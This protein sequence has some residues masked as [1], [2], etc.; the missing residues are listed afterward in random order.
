[1]FLNK[2]FDELDIPQDSTTPMKEALLA[3]VQQSGLLQRLPVLLEAA[4]DVMAARMQQPAEPPAT[5]PGDVAPDGNGSG[6]SNSNSNNSSSSA[7]GSSRGGGGSSAAVRT[8]DSSGNGDGSISYLSLSD[9]SLSTH[10]KHLLYIHYRLHMLLPPEEASLH[11][12]A[13]S[14][15]ALARAVH[16]A[17]QYDSVL[18]RQ[19]QLVTH[20]V[21]LVDIVGMATTGIPAQTAAIIPQQEGSANARIL[22]SSPQAATLFLSAHYVPSLVLATALTV[23]GL[24]RIEQ[25]QR[26]AAAAPSG[27]GSS[28]AAP[29]STSCEAGLDP[30]HEQDSCPS[31]TRAACAVSSWQQAREMQGDLTP[32]QQQ[33]FGLLGVD[34][35][36]V[37]WAAAAA[38][39]S[40]PTPAVLANNAS[41]LIMAYLGVIQ[42]WHTHAEQHQEHHQMRE[43]Q[44]RVH[45]LLPSL[46]LHY[47]AGLPNG[48]RFLPSCINT[49]Y[50]GKGALQ[51]WE[52]LQQ[53][54]EEDE[55]EE[56]QQFRPAAELAAELL[57]TVLTVSARVKKL[58]T[59]SVQG[60]PEAA[61]LAAVDPD[62]TPQ[63]CRTAYADVARLLV[64]LVELS[65]SLA[66][67]MADAAAAGMFQ[68]LSA[69]ECF[70]R[71]TATEF[72]VLEQPY[73]SIG[74][75]TRCAVR[76]IAGLFVPRRHQPLVRLAFSTAPG[77]RERQQLYSLL[78]SLHKLASNLWSR[79]PEAH[80]L[81]VACTDA[82]VA[83][84]PAPLMTQS[85]P[86]PAAP[87][88]ASTGGGNAASPH[89]TNTIIH[90]SVRPAGEWPA[91]ACELVSVLPS[92]VLAGRCCLVKAQ[93]LQQDTPPEV[94]GVDI[95]MAIALLNGFAPGL[96]SGMDGVLQPCQAWLGFPTVSQQLAAAGYDPQML[97]QAAAEAL[98]AW[99]DHEAAAGALALGNPSP[100]GSSFT[101][102]AQ[103][104]QAAGAALAVVAVPGVCN[105]PSCGNVDGPTELS[106]VSGQDKGNKCGRC[107]TA[108]YCSPQCQR[109]AWAQHKPVC[110]ALA[111]AGS[112]GAR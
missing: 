48:A 6:S 35:R 26:A 112:R 101:T 50:S 15:P 62:I 74:N 65:H 94:N 105:N 86:S 56:T 37:L 80:C 18:M 75:N 64:T 104:L 93:R 43:M 30:E 95:L 59:A 13:A 23:F 28:P 34:S 72:A 110:R 8:G 111:A 21:C 38:S 45:M 40:T 96:E 79:E 10:V 87:A 12:Y 61:M 47:A 11:T 41:V 16:T 57:P 14:A 67:A 20:A 19:Q 3:Q 39:S 78:F 49:A 58:L 42:F 82:L 77:S 4:A 54:Q 9:K 27:S 2:A 97:Q 36:V 44:A 91:S 89:A 25:Q 29:G 63:L 24:L 83:C 60:G 85:Q 7:D 102:L 99:N 69:L 53:Q 66:P 51:V 68:V 22:A 70:V 5:I 107:R 84:C 109:Q 71:S 17:M 106:I 92:L 90:T 32:C 100:L 46:L 76:K 103:K 1:M 73:D 88:P 33:L 55:Q 31:C 52:I 81:A 98:A 108:C